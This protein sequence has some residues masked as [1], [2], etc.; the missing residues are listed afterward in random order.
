[1]PAKDLSRTRL[2]RDFFVAYPMQTSETDPG[3]P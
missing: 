2:V 3:D 1:M